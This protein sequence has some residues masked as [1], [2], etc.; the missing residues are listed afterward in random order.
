M[1]RIDM[2][3]LTPATDDALFASIDKDSALAGMPKPSKETIDRYESIYGKG[4]WARVRSEMADMFVD[5]NQR[6]LLD[7]YEKEFRAIK[8]VQYVSDAF[9]GTTMVKPGDKE[10]YENEVKALKAKYFGE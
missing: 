8:P 7:A 4:S 2:D 3:G 6:M 1:A 5:Q 9:S 10:R